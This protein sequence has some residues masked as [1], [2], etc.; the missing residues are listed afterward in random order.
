MFGN[1][2]HLCPVIGDGNCLYRSLSHIIF[3]TERYYYTL[4]YNLIRKFRS[5]P[6]HTLNI[7]HM[8]GTT[9]E[10][11]L[12]E[13][14]DLISKPNEWGTNVELSILGVSFQKYA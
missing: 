13:H 11:E 2:L 5:T 9:S 14:F 7:M 1:T 6:Q 4:K 10:Q 8:S 12:N 3:G